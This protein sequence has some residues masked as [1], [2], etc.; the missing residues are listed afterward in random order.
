MK[1]KLFEVT[2]RKLE[3]KTGIYGR[4]ISKK[5]VPYVGKK[6][7]ITVEIVKG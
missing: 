1:E 2:V 5:L 3:I 6:I 7:K 4:I